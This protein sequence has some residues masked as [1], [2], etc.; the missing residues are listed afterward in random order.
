VQRSVESDSLRLR[1]A[2]PARAVPLELRLLPA[3]PRWVRGFPLARRVQVLP[4]LRGLP[5]VAELL[6]R[7]RPLTPVP[8]R[9]RRSYLPLL[10]E[11]FP[12]RLRAVP[13]EA[14]G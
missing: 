1:P 11:A 2:V 12:A 5:A 3:V 13:T 10:A 7:E 14:R 8:G 4:E 9:V 6:V